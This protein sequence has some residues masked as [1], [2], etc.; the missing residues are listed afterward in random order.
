MAINVKEFIKNKDLNFT[1]EQIDEAMKDCLSEVPIGNSIK[2]KSMRISDKDIHDLVL[3]YVNKIEYMEK[4]ENKWNYY[5]SWTFIST[6]LLRCSVWARENI[7]D[8]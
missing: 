1:K 4:E 6:K 5:V 7:Q 8:I 2:K 3:K